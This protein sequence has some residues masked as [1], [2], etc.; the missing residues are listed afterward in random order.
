MYLKKHGV[1]ETKGQQKI[2]ATTN[3]TTP[4]HLTNNCENIYHVYNG[5]YGLVLTCHITADQQKI[6]A[7]LCTPDL[8]LPKP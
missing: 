6:K 7:T 5:M 8:Q 1:L 4:H 3:K 2:A